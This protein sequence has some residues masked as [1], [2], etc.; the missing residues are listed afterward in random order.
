MSH[1]N[2]VHD[3][4]NELPDDIEDD[5]NQPEQL[6]KPIAKLTI[7]GLGT[8]GI[9]DVI[10]IQKWLENTAKEIKNDYKSYSDKTSK[11]NLYG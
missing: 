9:V 5:N 2:P 7:T 4:E 8:M 1:P 6:K 11:F 10:A 3:E